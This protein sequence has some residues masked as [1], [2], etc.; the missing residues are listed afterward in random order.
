MASVA[1]ALSGQ[2]SQMS[3]ALDAGIDTLSANQAITFV[4]Y[5]QT[6][7]PVDGFVFWIRGDLVGKGLSF[8]AKGSLHHRTQLSQEQSRTYS[9]NSVIFTSEN[10][11]TDLNRID[12]TTIYIATVGSVRFAFSARG[13]FF[14]E[15]DLWHYTGI[16]IQSDML[17]QIIDTLSDF[18]GRGVVV[19]NS[20]PIWLGL[21]GYNPPYAGIGNPYM[22]LYPAFLVPSNLPPPFASVY[23]DP[24]STQALGTA[25]TLSRRMAGTQLSMETVE[26]TMY[27]M[28]NDDA[29]DFVSCVEQYSI[30]YG[31]FGLRNMPVIRDDKRIQV[32]I[33]AMAQ[34]K[35]VVFEI[36][37]YQ[38]RV[39]DVARKLILDVVPSF[40]INS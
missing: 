36:N 26:I 3:A 25:P 19:S 7:L 8:C 38:T 34:K 9:T 13:G 21:N 30:D 39:R 31:T 4:Q 18:D 15:A 35:T 32:E 17:P 12:P 27:G 16:A 10:E 29:Q 6:I 23:I 33:G 14:R 5:V 28:R 40:F 11:V 1:E 2:K 22:T 37:Y 20:L 24:A